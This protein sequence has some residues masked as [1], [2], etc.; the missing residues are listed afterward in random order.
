MHSLGRFLLTCTFCLLMDQALAQAAP[1]AW[2]QSALT[3]ATGPVLV[4]SHRSCWTETSE[5][6]LDGIRRCIAEG[7][8][9]GEIDV[10]TTRDGALV[11]MHDETVDRTTNGHGAVADLTLAEIQALRLYARGGGKGASLTARRVPTLQEALAAARGRI[12]LNL[13]VKAAGI[14]PMVA[15]I[16]E[17]DTARDVL[18]NINA[19]VDAQQV[20]WARS[21]GIAV[22]TLYFD[23]KTGASA[24]SGQLQTMARQEPTVLQIIFRDPAV[25]GEAVQAIGRRPV[26]LL[27]NTMAIDIDSGRPMDLAG[28]Y[29]DT[30]AVVHPEQVWGKLIANG[31]SIIQTDEPQRL[32]AWLKRKKLR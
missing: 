14:G 30:V 20:A 28:P 1:L 16:L 29:L 22:Q 25:V 9:I 18:L 11:L 3:T 23:E 24:R 26:R 15:A 21:L 32:L 10:R 2:R 13:D 19:G 27:V 31:V 5:N 7:I 4:S 8:D 17:T 12:L 6:S